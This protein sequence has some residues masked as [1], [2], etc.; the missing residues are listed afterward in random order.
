[1]AE[2]DHDGRPRI[3]EDP[4]D[5]TTIDWVRGQETEAPLEVLGDDPLRG[6]GRAMLAE[7]GQMGGPLLVP[8]TL[9]SD[10]DELVPELAERE[11]ADGP[12][13]SGPA[14][15]RTAR[16]SVY[17]VEP[18]ARPL[19]SIGEVL[20]AEDRRP[21]AT[22]C[23][24]GDFR[25]GVSVAGNSVEGFNLD[26]EWWAWEQESGHIK[27]GHTSGLA[28]DWWKNAEADFD[29]AVELGVNALRLSVEWPRVEPGPGVF[30]DYVLQRYAEMLQSLR[31]RN[32]EP[33]V[34]LHHFSNPLWMAERGGWEQRRSVALF[35]RYVRRAVEA[36]AEHCDL[37]C[38]LNDPNL[39]AFLAYGEGLFPPG[40]SD[41]KAVV[42]VMRHMLEAHAAA[43]D[44]IHSVQPDARVGLS[45]NYRP[46]AAADPEAPEDLRTARRAHQTY[47]RSLVAS[48]MQGRWASPLGRGPAP[49]LRNRL[50]WIGFSYYGRDLVQFDGRR[51][52]AILGRRLA[53][54]GAEVLDGGLGE[55]Y[56]RGL[57][58]GVQSLARLGIPIYVTENGVPDDDDDL[59]PRYIVAHLYEVWRALQMSYPVVGYYHRTL[60][61]SFEWADG[62]TQRFGLL[63]FGPDSPDRT[64]RRSAHLFSDIT[65]TGSIS[66]ELIDEYAPLLRSDVLPEPVLD[67]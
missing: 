2:V 11:A 63:A 9:P 22:F 51:R 13:T 52:R 14:V 10:V 45:H 62:W 47:N 54:P 17:A 1:M 65:H 8:V 29:R 46:L 24:P 53:S 28:C 19:V 67:G 50:D 38:T 35:A 4:F 25:W 30:D 44:E 31:E 61:D 20:L 66:S 23:F 40:K 42:S 57:F 39:Y 18:S 36:L 32:I 27:L 34:T 5:G 33:M 64:P 48:L 16:T 26:S 60:L 49:G 15:A 3:G 7:E 55:F 59:R 56:P 58:E 6:E 37:W 12:S 41:S 43:Y 21:E